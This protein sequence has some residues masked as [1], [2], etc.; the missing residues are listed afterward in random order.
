MIYKGITNNIDELEHLYKLYHND[1]TTHPELSIV[2]NLH[3]RMSVLYKSKPKRNL[4][5]CIL[6]I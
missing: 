2:I 6:K 3:L 1:Y 5:F 4:C